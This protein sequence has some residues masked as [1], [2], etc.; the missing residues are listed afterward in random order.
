L[1]LVLQKSTLIM[2]LSKS[3]IECALNHDRA[4]H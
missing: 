2:I 1:F 4:V 3:V